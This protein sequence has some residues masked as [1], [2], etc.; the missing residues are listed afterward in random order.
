MSL[1]DEPK[2]RRPSLTDRVATVKKVEY[3]ILEDRRITIHVI[4][5]ETGLSYGSVWKIIHNELHMSKVSARWVPRLMAPLQRETRLELSRQMLTLLKQDEEDFFGRLVT[6]DESWIY[7]HDPKTKEMSKE[8]KHTTSPPPKKAKVQKSAGKVML[9]VIWNCCGV[10]LT[11]YLAKSQTITSAYYCTLL[12][13]LRDALKKKRR[14][15]LTKGVRLL[16]DNAHS[17]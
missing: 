10:I 5:H 17:S 16:A 15:M 6:M 11:D 7:L 12:N 1:T 14:G 4:M 8:R 9:S 3:L 2:S 13:K